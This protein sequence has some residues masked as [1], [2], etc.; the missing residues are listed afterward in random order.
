MPKITWN[1]A[2]ELV[3]RN[4]RIWPRVHEDGELY[5]LL[6][7]VGSQGE[8]RYTI[9]SCK[10]AHAKEYMGLAMRALEVG[11]MIASNGGCDA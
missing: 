10:A 5:L 11:V 8:P 6:Q 2:R 9:T 4:V 7:G 3:A 1:E